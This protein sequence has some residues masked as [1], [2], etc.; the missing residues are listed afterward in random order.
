MSFANKWHV[1]TNAVKFED[2]FNCK[3]FT[4]FGI[5]SH[6]SSW[7]T[8]PCLTK[9]DCTI[10]GCNMPN[11][12]DSS[13]L[14][15]NMH[16][17]QKLATVIRQGVIHGGSKTYLPSV[18]NSASHVWMRV[19]RVRR[20]LEALYASPFKVKSFG[21]KTCTVVTESG[22]EETV[23]LSRVKPAHVF[24]KPILKPR[25]KSDKP[26]PLE[27]STLPATTRTGRRVHFPAH[28]ADHR[29]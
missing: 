18:L 1:G 8:L 29:N 11:F 5:H 22:F 3:S 9:T 27:K 15:F 23:S 25:Q 16:F 20:P 4:G 12:A 24:Q 28:L 13:H 14:S 21:K 19:D 17:V 26:M 10:H 2:I 6:R 7:T